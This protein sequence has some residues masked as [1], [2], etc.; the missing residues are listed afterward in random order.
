MFN[1]RPG[2][3]KLVA[4]M[5]AHS[6]FVGITISLLYTAAS[7]LFLGT[8]EARLLPYVYILTAIIG[9]S[10]RMP[11]LQGRRTVFSLQIVHRHADFS[12]HSS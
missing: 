4:L 8:F 12:A 5:V 2:E 1:I 3:G 9:I 6:F 10:G 7:A 11:F